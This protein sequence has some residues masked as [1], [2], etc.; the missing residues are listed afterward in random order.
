M[1]KDFRCGPE[2]EVSAWTDGGPRWKSSQGGSRV[3]WVK[4]MGK[5]RSVLFFWLPFAATPGLEVALD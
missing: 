2:C 1:V 4:S 5:A 3:G